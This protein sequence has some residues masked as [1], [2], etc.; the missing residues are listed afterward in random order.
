MHN[1][2]IVEAEWDTEHALRPSNSLPRGKPYEVP[3]GLL[4]HCPMFACPWM[5][6]VLANRIVIKC[7]ET[8][9]LSEKEVSLFFWKVNCHSPHHLSVTSG[10]QKYITFKWAAQ[11]KVCLGGYP[12]ERPLTSWATQ[13]GVRQHWKIGQLL[14]PQSLPISWILPGS[15]LPLLSFFNTHLFTSQVELR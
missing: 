9:H 5:L 15:C 6:T 3:L 1:R 2:V 7:W 14:K 8:W 10:G 12:K 11:G 13:W 4:P